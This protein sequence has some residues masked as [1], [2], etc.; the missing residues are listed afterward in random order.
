MYDKSHAVDV[1]RTK[2][3]KAIP[4]VKILSMPHDTQND[5]NLAVR[6][7]KRQRHFSEQQVWSFPLKHHT[8]RASKRIKIRRKSTRSKKRTAR[9]DE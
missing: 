4:L 6:S 7:L 2:I 8:E 5:V 9:R 1:L 3:C